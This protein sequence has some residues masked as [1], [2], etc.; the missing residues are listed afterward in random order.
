MHPPPLLLIALAL[1]TSEE[2]DLPSSIS[3]SGILR[4]LVPLRK[5]TCLPSFIATMIASP[6]MFFG[7]KAPDRSGYTEDVIRQL[8]YPLPIIYNPLPERDINDFVS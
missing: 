5:M 3:S 2:D 7:Y 4:S 6:F 8:R 1:I